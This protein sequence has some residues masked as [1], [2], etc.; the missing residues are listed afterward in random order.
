MVQDRTPGSRL[1]DA[2]IVLVL[3]L[4]GLSC[5]LPFVHVIA[6]SLSSR[7]PVDG[8][9][10]TFWPI[11]LTGRN[12]VQIVNDSQFLRSFGVS[13]LRVALGVPINLLIIAL[14]AYP[15]SLDH[16]TFPGQRLIKWVLIFAMLFNGGLIP[17]YLVVRNL[18]LLDTIWVLVLPTAVQVFWI[19]VMI[20]FFRRL[21]RELSEAAEVDGASHWFILLRIYL[22]LSL[23]ALATLGLF[24]AVFHWNS[25]F[26]GL[27]FMNREV[28]YPLQSYLKTFLTGSQI[29]RLQN[30]PALYQQI[31]NGALRAAQII[32]ATVP[33][34]LVY[35]FLQR[36]FVTGLTLGSV[37]E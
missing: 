36:Y 8:N 37:K 19:I 7:A 30:N 4:V 26:D 28:N 22:P 25:W 13:V 12:Y 21:P 1:I 24:S 3:T 31:S 5:L 35:P 23:P 11:G 29:S 17:Q 33:I 9:L 10:V 32:V 18:R 20:N 6:V 2:G 27:I 16:N 14:T 34:L 15:L